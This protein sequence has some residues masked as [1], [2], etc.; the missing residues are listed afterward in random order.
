MLPGCLTS[1][2]VGTEITGVR[3][4]TKLDLKHT[5]TGFR[6]A[7][8][9]EPLFLWAVLLSSVEVVRAPAKESLQKIRSITLPV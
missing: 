9:H 8:V 7:S 1:D 4:P 2:D 6:C 3:R 5:S